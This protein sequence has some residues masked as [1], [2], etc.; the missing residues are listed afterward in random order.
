MLIVFAG[1][2]GTGKTTISR[3][4]AGRVRG[5]HLR[6]DT[7]EA[8]LRAAGRE[9]GEAGYVIAQALAEDMLRLGQ[10]VI[11]DC[12]NPVAASRAAWR[13]VAQRTGVPIVEIEVVRAGI[14]SRPEYEPWDRPPVVIDTTGRTVDQSVAEALG[15]L[16]IY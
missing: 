5:T 13:A 11:A 6:I 16:Q 14:A 1:Q 3:A 10:V 7:I 8:A 15:A 12:V 2:P 9:V 4:L